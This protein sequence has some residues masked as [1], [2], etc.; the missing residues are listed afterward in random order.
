[1]LKVKTIAFIGAGN[2]GS[3]LIRGLI[4]KGEIHREQIVATD[5][6]HEKLAKLEAEEG[7]Q[8]SNDKKRAVSQAEMVIL[9]VKPQN[10]NEVLR[11]IAPATD[12][13]K[14]VVSIAAGVATSRIEKGLPSGVRVIRVMPNTPA[15][16]GE[17]IAVLC[18]GS[19]ATEE[20]MAEARFVF[21]A[22]GKSCVLSEDLMDAVTG[23]SG[24]GPAYVFL[25]IEALSDAGV[26]VGLP[27]DV[28]LM[29]SVQTVLGAARLI[30]EKKMHPAQLREMVTSPGGTT[31]AG[32]KK[33]EE[34]GLRASILNAVEA[35][36]ARSRELG[37]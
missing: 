28:A 36:T 37:R 25:F 31:I 16:V 26:L 30:S 12:I 15:L 13:A 24:S 9:S 6:D 18:A 33:L 17:G 7:I 14:L 32:L 19:H 20:D 29:L 22:V 21:D 10:I 1:M 8:I 11:E 23:L 34:M 2:M 4:A 27:R 35:A 5:V 3:A